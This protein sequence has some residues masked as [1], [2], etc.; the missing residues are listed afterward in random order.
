MGSEERAWM[1]ELLDSGAEH[2]AYIFLLM[3]HYF[4]GAQLEPLIEKSTRRHE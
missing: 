4:P 3:L 2:E 1:R